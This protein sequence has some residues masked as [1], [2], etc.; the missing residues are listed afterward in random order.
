MGKRWHVEMAYTDSMVLFA[1]GWQK[2]LEDNSVEPADSLVFS[3]DGDHIFDVLIFEKCGCK[4]KENSANVSIDMKVKMQEKEDEDDNVVIDVDD[5]W[6][7]SS[8]V[9]K[10][11]KLELA[12]N[13]FFHDELE[14]KWCGEVFNWKDGRPIIRGWATVCQWNHVKKD[15][16]CICEFLQTEGNVQDIIKVHIIYSSDSGS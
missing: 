15:D 3:Y 6:N 11:F 10:D 12:E 1:N 2:F 9:L 14:R 5:E 13:I 4:K 16:V 8:K 7:V